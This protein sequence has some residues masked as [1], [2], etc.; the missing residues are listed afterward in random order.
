[1][2]HIGPIFRSMLNRKLSVFLIVLQ[3]AIVTAIF[4]TFIDTTK[5]IY[6]NVTIESGIQEDV[7][8][9]IAIRPI[10]S[11]LGYDKVQRDLQEIKKLSVIESAN[12]MRWTPLSRYADF[13]ALRVDAKS[14]AAKTQ[15]VK[16]TSTHEVMTTLELS[17]IAGRDFT[18]EDFAITDEQ[19]SEGANIIITNALAT[20]LFGSASQAVGKFVYEQDM[21]KEI[22][23][24]SE[25]WWGF[26]RNWYG[27]P[28]LTMFQ[29][30]H[31]E[32][33]VEYRY[34]MRVANAKDRNAVIDTITNIIYKNHNDKLLLWVEKVDENRASQDLPNVIYCW[35]FIVMIVV[36]GFVVA[37]AVSAQMLFSITQRFKHI[38]IRRALGASHNDIVKYMQTE[39]ML[40]CSIGLVLGVLLTLGV[41]RILLITAGG[42]AIPLWIIAISSFSLMLICFFSA[43]IPLRRTATISPSVATRSL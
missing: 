39:N 28:E 19:H 30:A 31:S 34:L 37:F 36:L 42:T 18:L 12:A 41:S 17:I 20:A 26:T 32:L 43:A 14:D 15:V 11:T 29:P 9:V 33:T 16:S 8:L 22:I 23:G 25:N 40:V 7:L 13:S 2:W 6:D 38:G 27:E 1:M 4:S 35:L 5:G 24:V 3:L 21:V 10:G